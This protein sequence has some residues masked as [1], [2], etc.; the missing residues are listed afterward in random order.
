MIIYTE[1]P[2]GIEESECYFFE[3]EESSVANTTVIL[4]LHDDMGGYTEIVK[5]IYSND[6]QHN[7]NIHCR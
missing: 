1:S 7:D 3:T 5:S 2:S 4:F 6:P